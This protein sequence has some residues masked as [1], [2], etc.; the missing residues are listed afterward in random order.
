[1]KL[2]KRWKERQSR[3]EKLE[4]RIEKLEDKLHDVKHMATFEE[5]W[6][7]TSRWDDRSVVISV[8]EALRALCEH[9]AVS[10]SV[11]KPVGAS[12]RAVPWPVPEK[13]CVTVEEKNDK[14]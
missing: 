6:A 14:V 9:L 4:K 10:I 12:V 5:H 2:W 11:T 3:I 13:G 7:T 8:R 1:M